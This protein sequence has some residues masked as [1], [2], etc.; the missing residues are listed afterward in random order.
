VDAVVEEVLRCLTQDGRLPRVP[1]VRY[2]PAA[3]HLWSQRGWQGGENSSAD[4]TTPSKCCSAQYLARSR[5]AQSAR[6]SP[7][8]YTACAWQLE[9]SRCCG[10]GDWYIF[11]WKHTHPWPRQAASTLSKQESSAHCVMGIAAVMK[12]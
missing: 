5:S 11:T 8:T 3:C 7:H 4:V 10:C 6:P 1:K 12:M 9:Q 2:L